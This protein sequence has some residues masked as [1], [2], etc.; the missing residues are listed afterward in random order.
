MTFEEYRRHDATALAELV[1]KG[2]L[3]ASEILDIAIARAEAVNPKINAIVHPTYE[4]ARKMANEL[5]PNLPFAGVPLL[6]KDL[7]MEI[8][9]VPMQTGCRGYKGYISKSDSYVVQKY[10]EAGFL[11][12]GKTN[13]PEFG[14]TPFTEPEVFGPACNPWNLER[15]TG[16]SSGG[17][18]A[19]VAAGITPIATAN[20][21]GGSIRIPASCCGLFGIKSSRGRVSL[22]PAAGELWNGAVAEGCVSRSVRDSAA[23]LDLIQGNAPGELYWTQAPVRPYVQEAQTPPQRL[24]IGFA[25]THT[26]GQTTDRECIAAVQHTARLLESLGHEVEEVPLPSHKEDLTKIFVMMVFGEAAGNVAELENYLGR[27]PRPSD[28]EQST[29]A[30]YLLGRSYSAMDFAL[31]KRQWNLIARR[32]AAFHERYDLLLTP[33]LAMPPFPTGSLQPTRQERLLLS[34]VSTFGLKG[35]LRANVDEL[36]EKIFA[37]IPFTPIANMTGQPS[38]SVPLHWTAD[39]LP[40]GSMFTAALGR[41]DLLFQLAGQLEQAQNWFDRVPEVVEGIG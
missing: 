6:V 29:W 20:D 9:G 32:M 8:A 14:L 13:T 26:L 19:A 40:V 31:A 22:G 30:L 27:K 37:F 24:R 10:R 23:L 12:L 39:G 38:M 15:T 33:T 17:S 3:Q 7:L 2:A 25:T 11:F 35:L 41:D 1:R 28:V 34:I 16:G 4:L 21:G 36:A 18:A 5:S